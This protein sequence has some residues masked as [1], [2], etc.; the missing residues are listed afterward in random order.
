MAAPSSEQTLLQSTLLPQ[1]K[2][3][4][5][6]TP[7]IFQIAAY[8]H[9]KRQSNQILHVTKLDDGNVKSRYTIACRS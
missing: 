4:G 7:E 9:V 3:W 8:V 6:S 5:T 1:P 2:G